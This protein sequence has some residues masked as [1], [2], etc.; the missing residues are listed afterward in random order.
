MMNKN[1][2]IMICLF[3]MIFICNNLWARRVSVRDKACFSNQR[4]IQGAVEMYNMDSKVKMDNLDINLLIKG[5]YLMQPTK[6]ESSCEYSNI[7][8]L[9]D[10]GFVF[11]KYHGDVKHLIYSEYF[12]DKEYDQHRKL[13]Q[14]ATLEDVKLNEKIIAEE[15]EELRKKVDA[16]KQEKKVKEEHRKIIIYL[17]LFACFIFTIVTGIINTLP[18]RSNMGKKE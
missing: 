4:V 6:P 2:T 1:L 17:I 7:G 3:C 12:N 5:K 13:P 11:C 15:R 9:S 14:S 16:I 18:K 10:D 8:D